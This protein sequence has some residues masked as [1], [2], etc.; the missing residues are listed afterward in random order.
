MRWLAAAVVG[1]GENKPLMLCDFDVMNYYFTPRPPK[2][3]EMEIICDGNKIFMGNVI[4]APQHFLDM[5]ELFAAWMPDEH[6]FSPIYNETH[7]D[8][9][10]MLERMFDEKTLPK[11]EW[12]VR[13]PGCALFPNPGWKTAPLC[14]FAYGMR[15]AGFWPK[16]K[17]I[18]ELRPV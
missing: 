1:F 13:S 14:H 5:A 11:P 10:R 3:G 16:H 18:P 12:L 8:D 7:M 15:A 6:D 17:F 2:Q 9:L 4:A